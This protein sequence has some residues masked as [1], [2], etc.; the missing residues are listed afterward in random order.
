[1]YQWAPP[2]YTTPRINTDLGSSNLPS[3]STGNAPVVVIPV[4]VHILASSGLANLGAGRG[5]NSGGS[6]VKTHTTHTH[7]IYAAAQ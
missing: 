4:V 3:R 5:F 2:S 1:M 6:P 7:T